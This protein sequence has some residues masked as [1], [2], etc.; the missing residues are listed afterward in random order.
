MKERAAER[1][2]LFLACLTKT[3]FFLEKELDKTQLL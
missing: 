3:I 2:T 1:G